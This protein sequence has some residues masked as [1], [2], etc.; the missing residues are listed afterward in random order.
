ML[1]RNPKVVPGR[2][3]VPLNALVRVGPQHESVERIHDSSSGAPLRPSIVPVDCPE[4]TVDV[5]GRHW[6]DQLGL[7]RVVPAPER[8]LS[9]RW[10]LR[11]GRAIG[12]RGAGEH[13]L[14]AR[15]GG[16]CVQSHVQLGEG[17]VPSHSSVVV[18]AP[19][20]GIVLPHRPPLVV[21]QTRPV[22]IS[23]QDA[24][25]VPELRREG[26][27]VRPIRERPPFE[28]VG[29]RSLD[30]RG[31]GREHVGDGSFQQGGGRHEPSEGGAVR[32]RLNDLGRVGHL[33]RSG[34]EGRSDDE[35]LPLPV[36]AHDAVL[37]D[38]RDRSAVQL[39]HGLGVFAEGG[40]LELGIRSELYVSRVPSRYLPGIRHSNLTVSRVRE[41]NNYIVL[42]VP[43]GHADGIARGMLRIAPD[44]T[45]GFEVGTPGLQEALFLPTDVDKATTVRHHGGSDAIRPTDRILHV[46]VGGSTLRGGGHGVVKIRLRRRHL[47]EPSVQAQAEDGAS[48]AH[49]DP[50]KNQGRQRG[51]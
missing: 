6:K 10:R 23:N 17:A 11:V 42:G 22:G 33:E 8:S 48:E 5:T 35:R 43:G 3:V 26:V 38:A 32:S 39:D 7:G 37:P 19:I 25:E 40:R 2:A 36:V 51:A 12:G 18:V 30:G 44:R 4:W 34:H 16:R 27:V 45:G 31:R 14:H 47:N 24:R 9:R 1:K 41:R 13:R 29:K 28:Q 20:D 50:R 46:L 49:H 15:R 21:G